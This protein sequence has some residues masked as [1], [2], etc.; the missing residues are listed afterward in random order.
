MAIMILP[1]CRMSGMDGENGH[2]KVEIVDVYGKEEACEV[3]RR[4][5][6]DYKNHFEGLEDILSRV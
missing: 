5:L 4:S 2:K 3:I 1:N 6:E